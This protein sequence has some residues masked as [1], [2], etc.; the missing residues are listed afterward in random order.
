LNHTSTFTVIVNEENSPPALSPVS[1]QTVAVGDTLSVTLTASDNDVPSNALMFGLVAAPAGASL[2]PTTGQ[3]NWTPDTNQ[4]VSNYLFSARVTDNGS[5]NLSDTTSFAVSV[6]VP[7]ALL[8]ELTTVTDDSVTLVW[9]A[10]AGKTYRVQYKN[11]LSEATWSDLSGD[12][13][14]NSATASKIDDTL[15]SN[16]QRFYRIV[17]FN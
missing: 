10:V 5:P 2:D 4:T 7:P 11:G 12:V 3:L 16:A 6:T 17:L 14:A 15:G 1:D 8:V 9:N 13:T